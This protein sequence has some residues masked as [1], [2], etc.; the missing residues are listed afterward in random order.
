M[1]I[2]KYCNWTEFRQLPGVREVDLHFAGMPATGNYWENMAEVKEI[3]LRSLQRAQAEGVQFVLFMHGH[4]T[5]RMGKQTARSVVRGLMRSKEATPYIIRSE[6]IQ[7]D[8]VFV[9][10]IRQVSV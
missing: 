10:R 2:K 9:A 8:S 6:C 1:F 3:T 5:S 4:S 7:H